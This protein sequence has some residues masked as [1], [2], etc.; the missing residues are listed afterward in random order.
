MKKESLTLKSHLY[1]LLEIKQGDISDDS[2]SS[3]NRQYKNFVEDLKIKERYVEGDKIYKALYDENI[4][5][6]NSV[7]KKRGKETIRNDLKNIYM[8]QKEYYVEKLKP[9]YEEKSL[10]TCRRIADADIMI[11][12]LE[13][14]NTV[15][16]DT[17]SKESEDAWEILIKDVDFN[18]TT[19]NNSIDKIFDFAFSNN[20]EDD[21]YN[22]LKENVNN[23]NEVVNDEI[24]YYKRK[25][26][27][28]EKCKFRETNDNPYKNLY[29]YY[30]NSYILDFY[31]I[32]LPDIKNYLG[33]KNYVLPFNKDIYT[34]SDVAEIY[35]SMTQ[36]NIEIEKIYERIKKS[37]SKIK[38][39]A[40]V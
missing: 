2:F 9:K 24:K 13:Y 8:A 21:S 37:I 32:A 6:I 20:Y 35:Q 36:I 39:Y 34:L 19:V 15:R 12:E 29:V 27:I 14:E 17:N 22:P 7:A 18:W 25:K 38:V 3:L 4:T 33:F 16:V 5:L 30:F 40:K 23:F 11:K 28:Y 10:K 1:K 31:P 26:E